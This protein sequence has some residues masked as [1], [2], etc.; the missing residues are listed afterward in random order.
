MEL[1]KL[2]FSLILRKK[3]TSFEKLLVSQ[4]R[5]DR[6]EET[7]PRRRLQSDNCARNRLSNRALVF[8]EPQEIARASARHESQ[9]TLTYYLSRETVRS[10]SRRRPRE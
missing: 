7:R 2:K 10:L 3:I 4:R 9:A 1:P 6:K 5:S 8:D